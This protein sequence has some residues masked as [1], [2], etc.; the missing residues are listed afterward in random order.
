M[1][2][3][4][5]EASRFGVRFACGEGCWAEL[6][7][8]LKEGLLRLDRR[9][10]GGRR[11]ALELRETPLTPVGDTLRL[12]MVL[13]RYSAEFFLQDG[14]QVASLTLYNAPAAAEGIAFF[15]KGKARMDLQLYD[16]AL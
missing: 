4:V 2:V 1:E 9:H 5:T 6:R 11:D 13:D 12:R 16:L 8:D 14:R 3:D 15:A 7:L 10:A